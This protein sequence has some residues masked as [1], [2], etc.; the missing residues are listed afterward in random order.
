MA[1]ELFKRQQEADAERRERANN[2]FSPLQKPSAKQDV[3]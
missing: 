1:I 3:S 2:Y